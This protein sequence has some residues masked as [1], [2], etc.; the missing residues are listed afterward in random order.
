LNLDIPS[1]NKKDFEKILGKDFGVK[2]LLLL[3]IIYNPAYCRE[4]K[5]SG[6]I[7][8]NNGVI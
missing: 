2:S 7:L 1:A 5:S 4:I 8:T 3:F 6:K